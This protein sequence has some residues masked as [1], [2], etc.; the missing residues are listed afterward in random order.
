M[1]WIAKRLGSVKISPLHTVQTGS[2][3]HPTSYSIVA[4]GSFLGV[5]C[6]GC[7]DDRSPPTSAEAKN[8]WIYKSTPSYVFMT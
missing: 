7:E 4:R 5:K 6:P 1:G 8:M 3:A 2:M